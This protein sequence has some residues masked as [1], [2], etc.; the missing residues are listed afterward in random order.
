MCLIIFLHLFLILLY[1]I[2]ICLHWFIDV[3]RLVFNSHSRPLILQC[4]V[5]MFVL[6]I[7]ERTSQREIGVHRRVLQVST[8]RQV[9]YVSLCVRVRMWWM[10]GRILHLS[11]TILLVLLLVYLFDFPAWVTISTKILGYKHLD[12]WQ[13][14][15]SK[16]TSNVGVLEQR[17]IKRVSVYVVQTSLGGSESDWIRNSVS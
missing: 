4:S 13:H 9:V 5:P 7:S 11:P 17:C 1:S 14:S 12:Y 16:L 8:S 15:F 2:T 6:A 10:S 3:Q